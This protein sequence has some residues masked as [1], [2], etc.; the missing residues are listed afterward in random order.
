LARLIQADAFEPGDIPGLFAE[1]VFMLGKVSRRGQRGQT[2]LESTLSMLVLSLILFGLLQIFHLSVAQMITDFSSFYSARSRASG[3]ADYLVQRT[4]RAASVAASG[5]LSWPETL[6]D[7]T[8]QSAQS[9]EEIAIHEYINGTRWLEYQYWFGE[10]EYGDEWS[11]S[12]EAPVTTITESSSEQTD[13]TVEASVGF[14]NY[15]FPFFDLM[16]PG[17]VWFETG[18]SPPTIYGTSNIMNYSD[19]YLN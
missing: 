3:F 8:E 12:V 16:D 18:T 14:M 6:E 7:G 9:A 4:S 2:I 10:N 1:E 17:R 15:P 13:G 11:S 5:P 19:Y